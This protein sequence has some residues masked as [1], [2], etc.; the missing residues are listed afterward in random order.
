MKINGSILT[1]TPSLKQSM[2]MQHTMSLSYGG[3]AIVFLN[4]WALDRSEW[5]VPFPSFTPEKKV[6]PESV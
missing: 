2:S 6:L 3:T 4:L 1:V 5:L